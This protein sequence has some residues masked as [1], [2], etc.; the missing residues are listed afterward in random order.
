MSKFNKCEYCIKLITF[1]TKLPQFMRYFTMT[2]EETSNLYN[3]VSK[4]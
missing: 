1:V 4:A 3:M 2:K